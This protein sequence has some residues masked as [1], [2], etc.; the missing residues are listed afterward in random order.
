MTKITKPL[1]M[2]LIGSLFTVAAT[3][4]VFAYA[5]AHL[6]LGTAAL[7]AAAVFLCGAGGTIAL[8]AEAVHLKLR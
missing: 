6:S 2:V 4:A 3:L 1:L 8:R 5:Q 7:V